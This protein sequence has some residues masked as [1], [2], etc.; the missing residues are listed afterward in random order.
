MLTFKICSFLSQILDK[1]KT[2]K[3]MVTLLIPSINLKFDFS[4]T[5][6]LLLVEESDKESTKDIIYLKLIKSTLSTKY[7]VFFSVM[8]VSLFKLVILVV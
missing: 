3:L 2:R 1:N 6:F 7:K 8:T 4:T 5:D